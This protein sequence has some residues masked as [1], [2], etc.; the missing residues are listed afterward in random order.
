MERAGRRLRVD[1]RDE[2]R[3]GVAVERVEQRGVRDRLAP[4]RGHA[5]DRRAVPLGDVRQPPAEEAGLGHDRRVAGLEQVG[6]PGLH[7]GRPGGGERE[8]VAV[9][10]APDGAQQ[11]HDL[12]EDRVERGIEVA[13]HRAAHGRNDGGLGVRRPGAAEQPVRGIEL[14]DRHGGAAW[15]SRP[16]SAS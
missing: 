4:R 2:A 14:V 11:R 12:V 15:T 16:S 6:E 13:E 8:D 3:F 9:R 10:H 7:R 1:D 5:D